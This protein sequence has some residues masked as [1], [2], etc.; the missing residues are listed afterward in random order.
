M[1][2]YTRLNPLI[3]KQF[4]VLCA[5]LSTFCVC[6]T[7]QL[8]FANNTNRCHSCAHPLPQSTKQSLYFCGQCLAHSKHFDRAYTLYNYQDLIAQLIKRFKYNHQLCIGDYFAYKLYDLYQSITPNNT[9]YD[10]IIPMPL[11]AKRIHQRGYNQV[12][13]LLRILAKKTAIKID[14]ISVSRIK[15]TR[16]L[17]S[18]KLSQR[19]NEIKGVFVAKA[20]NYQRVLLVDDVMTTG[21]SLNELA[22]TVI[23]AGVGRCDVMILARAVLN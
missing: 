21:S 18:L 12:L 10:A 15:A 7:C 3:P 20:M 1:G 16:P 19:Q 11:N 23:K 6:Q 9:H 17:S 2:I 5:E 14:T 22:K 13:E 4:C 8:T